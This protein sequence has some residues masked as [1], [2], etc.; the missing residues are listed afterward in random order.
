VELEDG[1][2]MGQNEN[3]HLISANENQEPEVR[4]KRWMTELVKGIEVLNWKRSK[5]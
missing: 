5:Q 2:T 1:L 4:R 3:G